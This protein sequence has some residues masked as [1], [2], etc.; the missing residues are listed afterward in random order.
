MRRR[1]RKSSKAPNPTKIGA[2]LPSNV[3]LAAEVSNSELFQTARSSVKKTPATT[4]SSQMPGRRVTLPRASCRPN[5]S[6][7]TTVATATR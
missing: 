3:A 5:G 7:S 2:S 6:A 4:A 1:S